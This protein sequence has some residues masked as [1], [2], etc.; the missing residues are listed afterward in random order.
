MLK[1]RIKLLEQRIKEKR[2]FVQV[3]AGPR[4]VGKTTMILEYLRKT[5]K[6][7]AYISADDVSPENNLWITQQWD[8]IRTRMKIE[9]R[10]EYVFVIDEIQKIRNWS[11]TV[12][13]EWDRDS[14]E[15]NNIKVILL[16]SSQL[17]LQ[18]GLSESLAGRFEIIRMTHWTFGKMRDEFGFSPEQYVWFGG[19]PGSGELIKDEKRF[20]DYIRNSIIE[21]TISKDILMMT[22]VDKPALLKNMFELGL[23]YS[24]Q[25]LS[26][27]KILGQLNDAGNT[28]TLSHYLDLL[29]NS[30]MLGGIFKF[31]KTDIKGKSSSPKL[32]TYNTALINSIMPETFLEIIEKPNKWGRL[33][34]SCIGAHLINSSK[35]NNFELYY[36]REKN[37]EVDFI[38]KKGNNVIAIEVKSENYC[39]SKGIS[40]FKKI[41]GDIKSY[42]IGSDGFPWQEFITYDPN[43]LF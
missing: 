18:K 8:L 22:R 2:R 23:L 40:Q 33:V 9:N 30:G 35:I 1:D 19:Y 39:K 12:K 42:I 3:I 6:S 13:L 26:Y 25:I 20:K 5:N 24:G 15:N 16:G 34:E 10:K 29:D 32:H 41:Y 28:T 31:K 43:D 38:M 37:Y 21:T 4:Q 17:L 11:S 14:R 36:W 7:N 27:N